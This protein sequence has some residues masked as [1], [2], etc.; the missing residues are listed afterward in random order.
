MHWLL[1]MDNFQALAGGRSAD[2]RHPQAVADADHAFTLLTE[3]LAGH[4]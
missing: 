4:V 2:E 3:G 1:S